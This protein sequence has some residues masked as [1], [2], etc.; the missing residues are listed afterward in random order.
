MRGSHCTLAKRTVSC[1]WDHY[2][3]SQT[4]TSVIVFLLFHLLIY[5]VAKLKVSIQVK[6]SNRRIVQETPCIVVPYHFGQ[7]FLSFL[8]KTVCHNSC[9]LSCMKPSSRKQSVKQFQHYEPLDDH[10]YQ[11]KLC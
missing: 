11:K 3:I 9:L 7:S 1:C 8:L 4:L 5:S 2:K 10:D 6:L